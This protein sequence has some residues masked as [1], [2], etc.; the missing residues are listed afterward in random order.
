MSTPATEFGYLANA[1]SSYTPTGTIGTGAGGV[2]RGNSDGTITSPGTVAANTFLGTGSAAG[3]ATFRSL[4]NT[5]IATLDATLAAGNTSTNF[6]SVGVVAYGSVTLTASATL[7]TLAG[8]ITFSPSTSGLTL[9]LPAPAGLGGF[10]WRGFQSNTNTTTFAPTGSN[11]I[12]GINGSV[13]FNTPN[14]FHTIFCTGAA[15]EV[16]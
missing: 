2:L 14:A 3:Q 15:F 6:A 13:T 12:N 1:P 10:E 8:R 7:N 9:T 4:P 16:G 5:N 11:T